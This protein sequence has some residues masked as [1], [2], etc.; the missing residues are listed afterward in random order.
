M[1]KIS[2]PIHRFSFHNSEVKIPL[3]CKKMDPTILLN[4]YIIY[5]K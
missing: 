1:D 4:I 3:F 2:K 5:T